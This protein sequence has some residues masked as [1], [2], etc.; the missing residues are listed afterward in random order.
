M[1]TIGLLLGTTTWG[2]EQSGTFSDFT[3]G[4]GPTFSLAY[5]YPSVANH[6]RACSSDARTRALSL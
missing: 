5:S 2:I 3:P 4:S 6:N 1:F